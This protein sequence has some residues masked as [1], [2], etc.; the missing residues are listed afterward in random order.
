V[1][2]LGRLR[3]EVLDALGPVVAGTDWAPPDGGIITEA[4]VVMV[5]M[6]TDGEQGLSFIPATNHFWSTE[7]LLR[8][9]L[10]HH[11]DN[12]GVGDDD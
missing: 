12:E 4:V 11:L 10:R 8:G 7:G 5:W 9:A 1:S 6:D 2:D 3:R